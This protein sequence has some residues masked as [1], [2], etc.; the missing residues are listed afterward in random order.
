MI[1]R[2]PVASRAAGP[3]CGDRLA[4]AT[5][6]GI[7]AV[8]VVACARVPVTGRSQ[9]LLVSEADAARLGAQAFAEVLRE[10][11]V[12]SGGPAVE[13]VLRVGRR[14][15]AVSGLRADW[16]FA[17]I[18]DEQKN[19]FALPGGKVA[20]YTGMLEVTRSDDGLAVVL[21]HE[22]GHV[23]A[24]H[25][26]ERLSQGLAAQLGGAVL[27]I[28][29]GGGPS[30]E[31]VLAAY[32][33]GAEY[34]VLRPFGRAQ[35]AEADEIGLLLMA[36]AGYDPREALAFWD[37]ME[38]AT[39]GRGEV[40]EFLSTHPSYGTRVQLLRQKLP[41]ALRVYE[42]SRPTGTGP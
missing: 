26:A 28:A 15:A 3:Q 35:E 37:R 5:R 24:R 17:V 38:R 16:R 9:L 18:K 10:S 1:E 23:V 8:L 32:G 19:A 12:V 34:G 2:R 7:V 40:P 6:W 30:T 31:T 42:G 22:I 29:L 13:Q 36:R 20:V 33:L 14:L 11:P 41:A 27:A 39:G 25:G 21:G 4:T